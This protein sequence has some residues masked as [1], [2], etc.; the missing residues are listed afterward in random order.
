YQKNALSSSSYPSSLC[1]RQCRCV[2]SNR[3]CRFVGTEFA[4]GTGTAHPRAT[5]ATPTSYQMPAHGHPVGVDSVFDGN[6][7][8]AVVSPREAAGMPQAVFACIRWRPCDWP[9]RRGR[10]RS[11][12][13]GASMTLTRSRARRGTRERMHPRT[14]PCLLGAFSERIEIIGDAADIG[15]DALL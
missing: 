10:W 8:I 14:R 1:E 13:P 11:V 9:H 2:S 15:A 6:P 7:A 4:T 3:R 5:A 12:R